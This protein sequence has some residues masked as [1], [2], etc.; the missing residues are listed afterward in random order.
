ME[1][2]TETAEMK[3]ETRKGDGEGD[4]GRDEEGGWKTNKAEERKGGAEGWMHETEHT[5][6]MR[7]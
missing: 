3:G 2:E 7:S 6:K 4:G 5:G 1:G